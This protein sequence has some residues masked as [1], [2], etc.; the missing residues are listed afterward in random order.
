[1]IRKAVIVVLALAAAGVFVAGLASLGGGG[2]SW[3]R[4]PTDRLSVWISMLEGRLEVGYL[5]V[6]DSA[7]PQAG[8]SGKWFGYVRSEA[9]NAKSALWQVHYVYGPFW[10]PAAFL[11][12]YPA[13]ARK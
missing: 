13:F 12:L 11:A 2:F 8:F 4:H 3:G 9:Y 6:G 10:A 5:V 7:E 1:M